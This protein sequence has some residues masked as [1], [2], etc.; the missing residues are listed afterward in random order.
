MRKQTV[1][2]NE[3]SPIPFSNQAHTSWAVLTGTSKQV[4]CN[5]TVYTVYDNWF[6]A[7]PIMPVHHDET[8]RESCT[9]YVVCTPYVV[10]VPSMRNYMS[11]RESDI[12]HGHSTRAFF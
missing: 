8:R 11:E 5:N 9:E 4:Y 10:G 12:V 7:P 2:E 3:I 6:G 1:K